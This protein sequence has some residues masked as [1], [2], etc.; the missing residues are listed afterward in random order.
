MIPRALRYKMQLSYSKEAEAGFVGG[1]E[2][3][4]AQ[5]LVIRVGC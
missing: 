2:R 5:Y 4:F 3:G 1:R